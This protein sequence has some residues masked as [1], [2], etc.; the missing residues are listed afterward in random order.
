MAEDK[1]LKGS[2]QGNESPQNPSK[3]PKSSIE[4]AGDELKEQAKSD[5][6]LKDPGGKGL[7]K[8][9]PEPPSLKDAFK[10]N[11]NDNGGK[12]L[13]GKANGGGKS[14]KGD[15]PEDALKGK[16]KD[17]GKKIAKEAAKPAGKAG[18]A[19]LGGNIFMGAMNQAATAAVGLFAAILGFI[20]DMVVGI[21]GFVGG[22]IMG[23]L[24][25]TWQMIVMAVSG[26]IAIISLVIIVIAQSNQVQR[27]RAADEAF[28]CND[29][30]VENRAKQK[31]SAAKKGE[32]SAE[33]Q[34]RVDENSKKTLS[35]LTKYGLDETQIAAVLGAWNSE[36]SIQPK[37]YETD[38]I[39]KE[40]YDQLDKDGPTA[41]SLV[42][43]WGAFLAMYNGTGLNE[44]GYLHEGKHYIGVGLGQWT[45]PRAKQ[46]WDFSKS[47]KKS[48]FDMDTQLAFMISDN[49]SGKSRLDAYKEASKGKSVDE[50]TALFLAMW[51][52]VPGNK[53]AARQQAAAERLIAIKKM[54]K[55]EAYAAS[56]LSL[57]NVKASAANSKQS[58]L[59]EKDDCGVA[60]KDSGAVDYAED[61]TGEFPAGITG[62]SW[63][64]DTLPKELKPFA[65]DPKALG[66][67]WGSSKGWY[68]GSGQCVD[69]SES[70]AGCLW[71]GAPMHLPGN[72]DSSA[73]SAAA[74]FGTKVSSDPIKSGA[75]FT[76]PENAQYGHTGIVAHIFK[77]RDILI[78]EQNYDVLSGINAGKPNT[79][80][81]RYVKKSQYESQHWKFAAP[82]DGK[83]DWSGKKTKK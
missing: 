25:F 59:N 53:L 21:V 28:R 10:K 3:E 67:T 20:V 50:A 8:D 44:S 78:L 66:L 74:A 37:R 46:L 14:A 83:A 73:A 60:L 4:K 68:S 55:D 13:L 34:A 54:D 11:S 47:I 56:I 15:S 58:K 69:L 77:N 45:G 6:K 64:P 19:T 42:G 70:V 26:T 5:P 1:E 32:L 57:A 38:Y 18:A 35:V 39:V 72:G 12:G 24:T 80:D 81:W 36:S 43:G 40:K 41:E 27:A 75:V 22:L 30:N 48:M 49:D 9:Q 29:A 63:T 71:K 2:I 16:L 17:T 76:S 79:W 52:G 61:G 33:D 31:I 7:D 82:K 65:H 62:I 51:E 23:L